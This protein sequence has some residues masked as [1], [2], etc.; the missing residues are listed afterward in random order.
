MQQLLMPWFWT[1][2]QNVKIAECEHHCCVR[3]LCYIWVLRLCIKWCDCWCCFLLNACCLYIDLW[4]EQ[5]KH[6]NSYQT[7]FKLVSKQCQFTKY[8]N[9]F[10]LM[11]LHLMLK[12]F[13][14]DAWLALWIFFEKFCSKI[15]GT[16]NNSA[17]LKQF[18][19]QGFIN[20]CNVGNKFF[21]QVVE[22]CCKSEM[23]VK[24]YRYLLLNWQ[25]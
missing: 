4:S 17:R 24:S 9:C 15:F 20:Q 10:V 13:V 2:W 11:Q 25:P 21:I 5:T 16:T 8:K 7:L 14:C 1:I 3:K 18:T 23:L 22:I 12:I 6:L 19:E